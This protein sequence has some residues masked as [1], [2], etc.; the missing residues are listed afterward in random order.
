MLHRMIAEYFF[1]KISYL[2]HVLN[3]LGGVVVQVVWYLKNTTADFSKQSR[4]MLIIEWQSSTEQCIQDHTTT[5]NINLGSSVEL[6]YHKKY[7][8][9]S[10]REESAIKLRGIKITLHLQLVT[11][12]TFLFQRIIRYKKDLILVYFCCSANRGYVHHCTF[13]I[14]MSVFRKFYVSLFTLLV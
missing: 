2:E 4:D 1:K 6:A 5:P 3:E 13:L 14:I 8:K 12:R 9:L 10:E 7:Y 11:C